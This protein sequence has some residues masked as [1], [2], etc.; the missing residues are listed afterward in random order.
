MKCFLFFLQVCLLGQVSRFSC[1]EKIYFFF[2]F[3]QNGRVTQAEKGFKGLSSFFLRTN[4]NMCIATCS[5]CMVKRH[6]GGVTQ[7]SSQQKHEHPVGVKVFYRSRWA[8][9]SVNRRNSNQSKKKL[10][11]QS[12][13]PVCKWPFNHSD[14]R[15]L[16]YNAKLLRK[17]ITDVCMD[18][19]FLWC[20]ALKKENIRT[21]RQ[22]I[23]MQN[24]TM[25]NRDGGFCTF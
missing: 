9:V 15:G 13:Q 22:M 1:Q 3:N 17:S 11:K 18:F 23:E 12:V 16:N 6:L 21:A 19:Y 7:Q 24:H 4:W 20:E 14:S 8:H 10:G 25:K 2:F 5:S